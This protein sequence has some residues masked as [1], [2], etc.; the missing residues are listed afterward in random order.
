MG[1]W[2]DFSIVPRLDW[3]VEQANEHDELAPER[4]AAMLIGQAIANFRS[5]LSNV[6][7]YE[8]QSIDVALALLMTQ[9]TTYL[10]GQRPPTNG[11]MTNAFAV[12]LEREGGLN[13]HNPFPK[14]KDENF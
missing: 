14:K 5:G 8:L 9:I 6:Q 12:L 13:F 7:V 3:I 4:K 11:L 10:Q 2:I 1:T